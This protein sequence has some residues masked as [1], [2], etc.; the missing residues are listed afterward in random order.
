VK[1]GGAV[2]IKSAGRVVHW[3]SVLCEGVAG[4]H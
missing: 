1:E 3:P 2:T 4:T